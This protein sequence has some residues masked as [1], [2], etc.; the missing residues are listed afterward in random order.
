MIVAAG[1]YYVLG[2]TTDAVVLLLALVPVA[3]ARL[4]L[5]ARVRSLQ[6]RLAHAVALDRERT[7]QASESNPESDFA[8][9]PLER[10][11]AALFRKV[12][13]VALAIALALFAASLANDES[14][15]LA[16]LGALTFA[17]AAVPA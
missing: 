2:E 7:D 1:V 17:M 4:A 15:A 13:V 10:G 11:A 6:R 5:H 12:A 8:P 3:A 9:T 16:S 14:F